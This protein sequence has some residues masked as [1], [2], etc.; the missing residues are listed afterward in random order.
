[1]LEELI[2][3]NSMCLFIGNELI[4]VNNN[5]T[6]IYEYNIDLEFSICRVGLMQ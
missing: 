5:N 6:Y 4:Y 2:T 3:R 1:M